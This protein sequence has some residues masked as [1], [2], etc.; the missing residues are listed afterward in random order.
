M[1]TLIN[2]KYMK[3]FRRLFLLHLYNELSIHMERY[4]KPMFL[5]QVKCIY[6]IFISWIDL[7]E[8]RDNI[9]KSQVLLID[10]SKKEEKITSDIRLLQERNKYR[11]EES[12]IS[13]N[14]ISNRYITYLCSRNN[15]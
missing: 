12:L 7:K 3:W 1:K 2:S 13:N 14:I 5:C 11:G 6:G 9:N 8:V 10:L 15:I 4:G